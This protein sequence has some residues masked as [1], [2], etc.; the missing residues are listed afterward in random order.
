MNS[1]TGIDSFAMEHH[2]QSR[3]NREQSQRLALRVS[4]IIDET[5]G[6]HVQIL[7]LRDVT[8]VFDYFVI[9]TGTSRRQMHAM[10]DEI[11]QTI[12]RDMQDEVRAIE[13][14]EESKWIVMDFGNVVVHLFDVQS[15]TYWDLENLWADAGRIEIPATGATTG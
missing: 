10:A 5:R 7:D 1:Y 4:Q 13:G 8:D 11:K 6:S 14:Y 15:R 2:D 9:A 3:Q 12:R